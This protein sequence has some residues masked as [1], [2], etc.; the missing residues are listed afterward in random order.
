MKVSNR[1]K[2]R[3]AAYNKAAKRINIRLPDLLGFL[4]EFEGEKI[5]LKT[6]GFS[7]K[8]IK[9]LK[10]VFEFQNDTE[11]VEGFDSTIYSI[12]FKVV[13]NA[14]SE[15]GSWEQAETKF[16]L[17]KIDRDAGTLTEVEEPH[18]SEY[19]KEDWTHEGSLKAQERAKELERRA[20][21]IKSNQICPAL[22]GV[23]IY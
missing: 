10:E 12:F 6:G 3:V 17:G 21:E 18:P 11:I 8:F 9:K 14:R 19:P 4:R 23:T 7:N 5:V 1:Q 2:A 13:V 22:R 15:C 20:E 16:Y